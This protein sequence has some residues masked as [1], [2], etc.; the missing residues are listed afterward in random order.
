[1]GVGELAGLRNVV[2]TEAVGEQ[3]VVA[4]A[5]EAAAQHMDEEP[6]DELVCRECHDFVAISP[7]ELS[8]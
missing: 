4:D 3:T 2:G 7:F 8:T 5:V 6:A 1:M